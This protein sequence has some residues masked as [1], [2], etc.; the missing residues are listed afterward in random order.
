MEDCTVLVLG[1][2]GFIGRN[3]VSHLV[4]NKLASHIRI[5]DK[6]PPQVAWLNSL[7]KS[8]FD[9][10]LVQFKSANLINMDYCAKA[11]E[12]LSDGRSFDYVINC[13]GET[14]YGQTDPIYQEGVYKL[15]LNCAKQ[16]ADHNVKRYIEISSGQMYNAEKKPHTEEASCEPWTYVAKWKRK[17]EVELSSIPNLRYTILRPA[18]I[19]GL[20]DKHGLTIRLLIASLYKQLGETLK[21]LWNANLHLSTI[22]A[23]DLCRAIVFCC[24]QQENTANAQTYNVVD[25][26]ETTQG[27]ISELIKELFDVKVDYY[28][29]L[30][31]SVVDL[32]NAAD[33]ANDKHLI[34]W[35]Q[36]C[37]KDGIQNTPLSPHMDFEVL[38]NK[39]LN[40][41]GDKLKRMGFELKHPELNA[42]TVKGVLDDFV[43]MELFPKSLMD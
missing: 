27:K 4:S 14:K 6:V 25:N 9:N 15:S 10:N 32:E 30:V 13:A 29:T 16:A 19:Y 5:V 11:F 12:P 3:L 36:A 26:N 21:L 2:C 43:Q 38:L 7:H 39:H 8:C 24:V 17:V 22:H 40:L 18:L 41:S 35:F 37:K 23:E 1:G 42:E 33:E 31:S 28:G 20:G 34:P